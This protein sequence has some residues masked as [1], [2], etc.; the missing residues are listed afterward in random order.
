MKDKKYTQIPVKVQSVNEDEYSLWTVMSTN[1]EDRHGDEVSQN[2]ELE[3]F[4][5]N[6]VVLNGHQY[7]DSTETIGRVDALMQDEDC[8]EG[9]VRFAVEENPKA[10]VIFDLYKGGFLN[11]FSVGFMPKEDANELL[12]LSAVSVPANAMALAKAKGIDTD[13]LEQDMDEDVMK[14]TEKA[15]KELYKEGRTLSK[16]NKEDV[17]KIKELAEAIL[18]RAET[19]KDFEDVETYEEEADVDI[20]EEDKEQEDEIVE[21]SK[22]EKEEDDETQLDEDEEQVE[23]EGEEDETQLDENKEEEKEYDN[24]KR[25]KSAIKELHQE[26]AETHEGNV[27]IKKKKLHKALRQLEA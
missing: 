27:D 6:P 7:T 10:K 15:I 1:D 19:E 26:V 2:W 17:E 20:E 8:L 13:A 21:E 4:M 9:K 18:S 23:K 12:E 11:A 25:I 3:N 14:E 5:N 16:V 22:E 24:K